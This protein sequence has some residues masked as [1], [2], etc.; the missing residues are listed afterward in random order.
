[1][2]WWER[3]RAKHEL[4]EGGCHTVKHPGSYHRVEAGVCWLELQGR[5]EVCATVEC[6]YVRGPKLLPSKV[7][8]NDNE[9]E[10]CGIAFCHEW[11]AAAC[12]GVEHSWGDP[13]DGMD[14]GMA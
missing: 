13:R 10:R 2:A 6:C 9:E 5:G 1:M 12:M 3:G 7:I 8:G 4:F 11:G 14:K